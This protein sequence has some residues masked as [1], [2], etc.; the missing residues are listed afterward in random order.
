M[1]EPTPEYFDSRA[2]SWAGQYDNDPRFA[3]RQAK[4]LA[5]LEKHIFS[6][7]ASGAALDFGCG[8]GVFSRAL[9]RDGWSVTGVDASTGMIEQARAASIGDTTSRLKYVNGTIDQ[10]AGKYDLIVG[11]S[12]IEYIADDTGVIAKLVD[13]LNQA[14]ILMLSVPNRVGMLRRIE[15]LVFQVRNASNNKIFAGRGDYLQHQRHQYSASELDAKLLALGMKKLEGVYLNAGIEA[16]KSALALL[17]QSWWAAMYC[18]V[19]VKPSD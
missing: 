11:L 5:L 12:V 7:R 9:V 6:K 17:E 14:G 10:V 19:Y 4:I 8:S 3:R 18:G 16:S 15:R 13:S 2:K 1:T